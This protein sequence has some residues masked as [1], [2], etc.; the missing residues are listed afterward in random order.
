MS[1]PARLGRYQILG[2]IGRGAMGVVYR[3]FDPQ[4]ERPV[5]IKAISAET[6]GGGTTEEII[7]RFVREAKLAARIVHPGVVTIYDA[8]EDSGQLYLVM[9]LVEGESLAARLRRGDFP[10]Q[11]EALELV[12]QVA[13]ALGAA[14]QAGVV[15]RDVKPA[16]ILI[17]REGKAKV[18]DF[19]VAKA[20]G[21]GTGLTRTGTAVGSPAYMSPE[22]VRGEHVDPRSDL[23][24]LGVILYEML[25]RKRPFPAET[26]TTLVYQILNS[27]PFA[28]P[29]AFGTLPP[30]VVR[31]LQ[32][33][34]AKDP[35]QRIPDAAT[36]ATQARALAAGSGLASTLGTMPTMPIAA[37]P[38][39]DR[40]PS[41]S[42]RP[43]GH[44]QVMWV[45]LALLLVGAVVSL[46]LL[47]RPSPPPATLLLAD[48]TPV[49]E[50]VGPLGESWE[51]P[52]PTAIATRPSAPT[53]TPSPTREEAV[54]VLP[55][56]I[57]LPRPTATPTPPP[58]VKTYLGRHGAVF[59]VDPEE[60]LVEINGQ[61]IGIADDWDGKGGG[62][63]YYFP[64]PGTYYA[65][66]SLAGH[67]TVWVAIVITPTAKEEHAD[68]DWELEEF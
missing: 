26:L 42:E 67:K 36:F 19:G 15:H 17:T 49:P 45:A 16:N 46:F 28:D 48:P 7:A 41:A 24:S 44:R 68:V 66:L 8:G 35:G 32:W 40:P 53:R 2:E 18:S 65:K 47:R 3:A 59:N 5:A 51:V 27:D 64:G 34:L 63:V 25:L 22:Q 23:F 50:L 14:H 31:F 33:C 38:P 21:E 55:P 56:P 54:V 6:V 10:R 57:A 39:P 30:E 52:T 12:A 11:A 61:V 43:R 62:K 1:K 4:L 29:Q 37:A 9:E 20:V 13:E 60:A 58:V